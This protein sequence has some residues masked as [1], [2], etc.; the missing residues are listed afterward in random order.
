MKIDKYGNEKQVNR[1]RQERIRF[2]ESKI[3]EFEG[4]DKELEDNRKVQD[5]STAGIISGKQ[6]TK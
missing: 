2:F 4:K 1:K 3:R 5:G 6:V